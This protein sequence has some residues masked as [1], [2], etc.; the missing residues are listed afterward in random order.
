MAD[1]FLSQDEVDA[2]LQG[3]DFV[4]R[5]DLLVHCGAVATGSVIG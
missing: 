2:L 4:L 1:N 3:V 5:K